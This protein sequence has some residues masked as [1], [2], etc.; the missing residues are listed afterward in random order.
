[1]GQRPSLG[2]T[3]YLELSSEEKGKE[4]GAEGPLHLGEMAAWRISLR[5]EV[6]MTAQDM[7][8]VWRRGPEHG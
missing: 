2:W 3:M 4:G 8:R 6:W 1:M 5:N 7:G